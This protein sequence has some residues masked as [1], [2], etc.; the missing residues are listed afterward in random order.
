MADFTPRKRKPASSTPKTESGSAKQQPRSQ[1]M[2]QVLENSD[3]ETLTP[4]L[5]MH[6]QRTIGNQ[7]VL[8]LLNLSRKTTDST[9]NLTVQRYPA[10]VFDKPLKNKRWRKYT[11]AVKKSDEGVS[12]GVYFFQ[13]QGGEVEE[14]VVKPEYEANRDVV[15]LADE[16]LHDASV[17]VPHARIV[18]TNSSEQ[19]DIIKASE[20]HETP[21]GLVHTDI[22]SH[23]AKPLKFLRVMETV[24]GHSLHQ[25]LTNTA[26]Q[27]DEPGDWKMQH[28]VQKLMIRF[29]NPI[30]QRQLVTMI[31]TDALMGNND[32]ILYFARGNLGN[33]MLSGEDIVAIDSEAA[34]VTFSRMQSA[35]ESMIEKLINNPEK[36]ID[37]FLSVVSGIFDLTDPTKV[38]GTYFKNHE[39][40]PIVRTGLV[41][42]MHEVITTMAENYL[43]STNNAEPTDLDD[44]HAVIE[45]R[46]RRLFASVLDNQTMPTIVDQ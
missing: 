42:A 1:R 34:K 46:K 10:T 13:S 15:E 9:Q 24:K 44:L 17:L 2:E 33:V 23:E 19:R 12:G 25:L 18:K 28:R 11:T 5:V 21:I 8:N 35:D 7:A 43:Y 3:Q 45:D 4:E 32:R 14:V 22:D 29:E 6:L 26:I 30:F 37:G 20:K 40:Y 27:D 31:V 36:Y 38:T 39:L 41:E 16:M